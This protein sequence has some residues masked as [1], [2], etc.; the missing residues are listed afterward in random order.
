[1]PHNDKAL[2][3]FTFEAEDFFEP[4][5]GDATI[6]GRKPPKCKGST[7]FATSLTTTAASSNT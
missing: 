3:R 4:Y 7:T 2:G 1:L 6:T 5:S